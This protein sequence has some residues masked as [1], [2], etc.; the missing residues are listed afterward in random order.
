[1]GRR[2]SATSVQV[3]TVSVR[4]KLELQKARVRFTIP[5]ALHG[6]SSANGRTSGDQMRLQRQRQPSRRSTVLQL[7]PQLLQL[8]G[9]GWR[10]EARRRCKLRTLRAM[11]KAEA[12]QRHLVLCPP[13]ARVERR[14]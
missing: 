12:S 11:C 5:R 10:R 7:R 14:T 2:T 13:L 3:T 6:A 4:D 1:M 8:Q 9:L